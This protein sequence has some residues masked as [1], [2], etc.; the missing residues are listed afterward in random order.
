MPRTHRWS[1]L[2]RPPQQDTCKLL[3]GEHP[4]DWLT[5]SVGLP[6]SVDCPARSVPPDS[7]E[8]VFGRDCAGLTL[9]CLLLPPAIFPCRVTPPICLSVLRFEVRLGR[10]FVLLSLLLCSAST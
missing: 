6:G 3:G 9:A 10:A 7:D 4:P 1:R 5:E 2:P 8:C